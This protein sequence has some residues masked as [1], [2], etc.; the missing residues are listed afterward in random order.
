MSF[1]PHSRTGS[2]CALGLTIQRYASFNPH[3]RT[4]SDCALGLTIQRYASFNPHSRTGSDYENAAQ[5]AKRKVSIHTP[6]RGVTG[7][8]WKY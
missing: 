6:A 8:K 3:S 1:N 5:M 4:G 2:D 7:K